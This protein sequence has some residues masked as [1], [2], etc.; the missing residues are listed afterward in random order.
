MLG[1]RTVSTGTYL[2]RV[3]TNAAGG[4]AGSAGGRMAK[5]FTPAEVRALKRGLAPPAKGKHRESQHIIT[6]LECW[7]AE[8]AGGYLLYYAHRNEQEQ[9]TSEP[10]A[11]GY[12]SQE[13]VAALTKQGLPVPLIPAPEVLDERVTDV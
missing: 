13:T 6:A 4:V 10:R 9:L 7:I 8:A 5:I 2:T 1:R 12:L 3:G 11:I